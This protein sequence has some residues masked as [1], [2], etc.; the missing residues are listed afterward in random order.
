MVGVYIAQVA[1]RAHIPAV[2]A[3]SCLVERLRDGHAGQTVLVVV[4]LKE[5]LANLTDVSGNDHKITLRKSYH[6]IP[7]PIP[8]HRER[9][10]AR[11]RQS[12]EENGEKDNERNRNS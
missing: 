12:T 9:E 6:Y 4:S 3:G 7:I 10:R 11:E 1:P 5:L 2:S 8:D